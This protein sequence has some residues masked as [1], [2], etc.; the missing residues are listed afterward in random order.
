ME[1]N[2]MNETEKQAVYQQ[3]IRTTHMLGRIF[4]ILVLILLLGAPFMMGAVLGTAPNLGAAG[5]AFLSIGIV[6]LVSCIAEYI[7]YV[8]MLGAGGTYLAFITGNLINMK[9]PCAMTARDIVG[10]KS[11][12]T[13]NEII[14]TLSIATSSLVTILVLAVGVAL[15]IP[16]QPLLQDPALQPAFDNVV[17]ALFGAMAFKYFRGHLKI[18]LPPLAAMSLLF[19][20]LPGLISS[21]SMMI[22][23]GGALAIGLAWYYFRKEQGK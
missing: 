7:I 19:V 14:S 21:A 18:A 16:L 6:Y 15:L 3:Y 11:G 10:A 12:T 23:P 13:E 9:V 8:P 20:L 22:I 17:P 4:C 5:K 2:R 1:N